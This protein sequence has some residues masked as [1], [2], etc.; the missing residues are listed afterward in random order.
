MRRNPGFA[1]VAVITLALGIGANTAI[2]SLVS[3]YLF[4]ALPFS[5]ADRLVHLF[6]IDYD[7]GFNQARFSLPQYA[8]YKAGFESFEDLG[9]YTYGVKN[10]AGH[11]EPESVT[12]GR[13]TANT[14]RLLGVEPAL[15]R[16]FL[17]DEDRPGA[18]AVA[19]LSHGLW[20]RRYAGDRGIIGQTIMLD[21]VPHNVIGVMP[22]DFV[23]PY[24]GVKMWT[25][26]QVEPAT[27]DRA[28]GSYLI[29]G[30]L[31]P[32]ATLGRAR[33]EM[34][35]IHQRLTAEYP[36][37]DGRYGVRAVPIRAGLLFFYDVIRGML[38]LLM[39]AVGFV[40]LI[41]AA[42]VGNIM[43]ARATAREREV[44]IRSALGSSRRRLIRQFLTE[45][46]VLAGLGAAVGVAIAVVIV[47]QIG[48][49]MPEDLYRVGDAS[50]DGAALGFTVL[51]SVVAVVFFGFAP[52][53]QASR[54]D[55]AATIKEGGRGSSAGAR[56][57]RLRSFLV[58]SQV[59]MTLVL[60]IGA[61][62]TIQT[63]IGMQRIDPGFDSDGA[64]TMRVRLSTSKYPDGSQRVAFQEAALQRIE[65]L[66]EVEAAG[67]VASLPLDFS[68]SYMGFEVEGRVPAAPD[69]RLFANE[70]YVTP[71]YFAAMRI[72][73]LRGRPFNRGDSEDAPRVIA[74]NQTM[75]ERFWPGDDPVGR[76]VLLDPEEP[77]SDWATIVAVVGDVRHR[78]L[79]RDVDPQIYIPQSQ[80][81]SRAISIIVRTT[82]DPSA[83]SAAVREAIWSVDPAMP[84]GGARTLQ[85]VLAQSL[86]PFQL[87]SGLLSLFGLLA[88]LL[89][90]IGLYGVVAYS[91]SRRLSEFGIRM[92]LGAER[93]DI[94]ALVIRHGAM[95]T[96]VG[97]AIGLVIS[98][99]LTRVMASAVAGAEQPGIATFAGVA[100]LLTGVALAASYLP[101]RRAA[102][103]EPVA[104]LRYE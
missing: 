92:A 84:I 57:K 45:S 16:G 85:Q 36:E 96:G 55:V 22:R 17:Q 68:T 67:G 76:R 37:L 65:A 100:L 56:G 64:L 69:E 33:V 77:Q 14:M 71:G 2:F 86:G 79:T 93:T 41:V 81:A 83:V 72:P 40:L 48:P 31:K 50:V 98:V 54:L 82:G 29:I 5:D 8:D 34:E 49:T 23:F 74:I 9:V 90:C 60:L 87:V 70:N 4:R 30:R 42:N 52:A 27:A 63:L 78:L 103:V 73:L 26:L 61:A 97:V 62:V 89:A 18:Q 13:V 7:V 44:A 51:V 15:G 66:P 80:D 46:A 102:K 101:A 75:A 1:A 35:T 10:V 43:L 39:A 28:Q 6:H 12:V 19:I 3:P 104:A 38:L 32:G 11:G 58:V 91:V 47:R 20:Q 21:E 59:A 24:G 99:A 94:L 25:A 95:L 53:L 88:L